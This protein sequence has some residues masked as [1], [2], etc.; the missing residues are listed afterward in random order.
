MLTDSCYI[1]ETQKAN[2]WKKFVTACQLG[3][4]SWRQL[5]VLIR[6]A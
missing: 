5:T 2:Y 6:H 1:N 4:F 3:M